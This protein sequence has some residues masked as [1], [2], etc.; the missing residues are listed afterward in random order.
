[1]GGGDREASGLVSVD[2]ATGGFDWFE[3]G[4]DE[5]G[6]LAVGE[7]GNDGVLGFCGCWDGWL[8]GSEVLPFLVQVAEGLTGSQCFAHACR[9]SG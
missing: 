7:G 3:G 1:M 4:V 5:M 6:A 9:S 8:G 2:G